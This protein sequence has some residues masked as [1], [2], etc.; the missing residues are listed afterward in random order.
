MLKVVC[1]PC[2]WTLRALRDDMAVVDCARWYDSHRSYSPRRAYFVCRWRVS[3]YDTKPGTWSDIRPTGVRKS[4]QRMCC[5]SNRRAQNYQWGNDRRYLATT[6][7]RL[8]KRK[9]KKPPASNRFEYMPAR[10][11]LCHF[12]SDR[13]KLGFCIWALWISVILSATFNLIPRHLNPIR[14]LNYCL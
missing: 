6:S 7:E 12:C 10:I 2:L 14:S 8:T 11:C 5:Q 9:T 13:T 3:A 1:T 4:H